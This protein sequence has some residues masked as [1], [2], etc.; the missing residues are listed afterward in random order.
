MEYDRIISALRR[1][2]NDHKYP[3]LN[4]YIFRHDWESDWFSVAPSGYTYE[5]EIKISLSDFRADFRKKHKHKVMTYSQTGWV[6]ERTGGTYYHGSEL[7]GQV[8]HI[9]L[10]KI[11]EAKIPNR[12]FYCCP[13]DVIPVKDI[14]H[15]AGLIYVN[16]R[17]RADIVKQSPFLHKGTPDYSK[18]LLNKFYYKTLNLE[19]TIES[20]KWQ[21]NSKRSGTSI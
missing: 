3:C 17:G 11:E 5:V 18:V 12:F 4:T 8:S 13:A 6:V 9:K 10:S 16:E 15:Y 7:C 14:P 2:F 20:L 1:R 19:K 21:I